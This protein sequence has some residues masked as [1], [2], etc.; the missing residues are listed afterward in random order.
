[1]DIAIDDTLT[2]PL[3]GALT[4]AGAVAAIIT[5]YCIDAIGPDDTVTGYQLHCGCELTGWTYECARL[6]HPQPHY[7]M[8]LTPGPDADPAHAPVIA[9]MPMRGPRI[10]PLDLFAAGYPASGTEAAQQT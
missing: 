4:P 8:R 3:C 1:M 5:Q 6:A 9:R 10:T 7:R 2:C